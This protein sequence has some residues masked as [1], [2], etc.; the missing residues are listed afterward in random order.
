M[1]QKQ[2]NNQDKINFYDC[3]RCFYRNRDRL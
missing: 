2:T 3:N 1:T